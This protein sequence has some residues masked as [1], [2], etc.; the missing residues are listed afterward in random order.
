M[1]SHYVKCVL[2]C[3]FTRET[4]RSHVTEDLTI[5]SLFSETAK[6]FGALEKVSSTKP[7]II[8]SDYALKSPM[9]L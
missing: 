6:W 4:S 5:F 1:L 7:F 2:D 9:G 8:L 3:C